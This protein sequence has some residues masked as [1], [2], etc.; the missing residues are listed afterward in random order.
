MEERS[1]VGE[2]MNHVF[3]VL[4]GVWFDSDYGELSE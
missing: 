2:V 4:T 3:V 1:V